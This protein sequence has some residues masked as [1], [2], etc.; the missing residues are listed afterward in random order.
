MDRPADDPVI[1]RNGWHSYIATFH[2]T[3]PGITDDMLSR[4]RL[5]G[6]DPYEWLVD[7]VD[8]NSR[9][10]DL[11]CGSAPTRTRLGP[12]WSG[13]DRSLA[14]LDRA[15]SQGAVAV[16]RGDA[17]QLPLREKCFDVVICSMSLMLFHPLAAALAEIRRVLAPSGEVRVL[18]P[19]T[20]PLNT[21]DR[22]RYLRLFAGVR[23][24]A[25]FP[26]SA[27]WPPRPIGD[28]LSGFTV[29]AD[30]CRR[31]AYPID[32]RADADRLVESLYLPGVSDIR[33]A[34]AGQSVADKAPHQIGIPLRKLILRPA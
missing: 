28:R 18:L 11:G 5:G 24:I 2:T 4:C 14:E 19:A 34:K 3:R 9:V 22:V 6:R 13:L 7:G 23:S 10:L 25:R 8:V 21:G 16:I 20:R 32:T 17:R 31:F 26:R 12:Q 30:E 27:L 15:R 1:S 33:I 29:I